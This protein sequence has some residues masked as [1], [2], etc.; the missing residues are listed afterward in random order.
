MPVS[1]RRLRRNRRLHGQS[2]PR[3]SGRRF[4]SERHARHRLETISGGPQ[5]DGT[6]RVAERDAVRHDVGDFE[7]AQH[8]LH[9]GR[10]VRRDNHAQPGAVVR[11]GERRR[12]FSDA[13]LGAQHRPDRQ[14]HAQCE[15]YPEQY[16]RQSQHRRR[17]DQPVIQFS[18]HRPCE[19][20]FQSDQHGNAD[21]FGE[22]PSEPGAARLRRRNDGD[23]VRRL[24]AAFYELHAAVYRHQCQ[25]NARR[26][27][28]LS[29]GQFKPDGRG[30]QCRQRQ[31]ALRR[32]VDLLLF[33][34]KLQSVGSEQYPREGTRRAAPMSIRRISPDGRRPSSTTAPIR[35][36]P[37]ATARPFRR[38]GA[39]PIR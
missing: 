23:G 22:Q 28:H 25:R 17:I 18:Q 34:R 11:T 32:F 30:L 7:R 19:L 31:C 39:T 20:Q 37:P 13:D 16:E 15:L 9:A 1:H 21:D 10:R 38:S 3:L 6:G 5:R 36:S 12:V 2:D 35:R 24:R 4:Q 14:W 26:R 8:R 27:Q 29:A 33:V